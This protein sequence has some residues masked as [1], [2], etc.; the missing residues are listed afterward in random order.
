MADLSD[1]ET[2]LVASCISALYP[3]GQTAVGVTRAGIRIYRGWP[4]SAAL[5]ADLARGVVNVSVF[6]VPGDT[7]NTTRWGVQVSASTKLPQLTVQSVGDAV[8]FGGIAAPG[9]VAGILADD[10]PYV[11]RVGQGDTPGSVAASLAAEIAVDRACS[12]SGTIVTVPGAIRLLGRVVA[13]AAET[14]EWARQEQGFRISVWAPDPRSRDLVNSTLMEALTQIAFLM[15]SDGSAG[16]LRYRRTTSVDHDQDARLY[17]RD[18]VYDVE[19]A[20]TVAGLQP[21]MLF[22]DVV[23]DGVAA[24]G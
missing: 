12:V 13:D 22:G 7:R 16:R 11:R 18:L 6:P 4:A 17:R 9:Q 19:Y 1:V 14:S 21:S 2:A 15:F 5:D 3:A 20:T 23:L 10:R 24:F 8:S